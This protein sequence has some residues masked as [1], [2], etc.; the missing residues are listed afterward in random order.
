MSSYHLSLLINFALQRG[1]R[2]AAKRMGSR[3]ETCK[4]RD[5]QHYRNLEHEKQYFLMLIL[6]DFQD[7]MIIPKDVVPQFKGEIPG[8]IKLETRNGYS[9]TIVVAKNQE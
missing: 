2:G 8:E 4:L 1:C 5:E 6:G 7:A 3:F 9:H